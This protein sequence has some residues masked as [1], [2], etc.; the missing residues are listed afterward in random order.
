MNSSQAPVP[1]VDAS[2]TQ[3]HATFGFG[4]NTNGTKPT[5]PFKGNTP[6]G[7][8]SIGEVGS[9]ASSAGVAVGSS[10]GKGEAA[11]FSFGPFNMNSSQAP[12][13][14]VGASSTQSHATFGFGNNTNGTKPT[15]PFKGN[16]PTVGFSIGEVGS[17]ASS[18]GV[19]VGSS[20]GKGEAATA[21][22]SQAFVNNN[23]GAGPKS[24]SPFTQWR[25]Y[26]EEKQAPAGSM[27]TSQMFGTLEYAAPSKLEAC[28][29]SNVLKDITGACSCDMSKECAICFDPFSFSQCKQIVICGHIF[30]KACIDQSIKGSISCPICRKVSLH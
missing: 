14:D 12:A 7:G 18:A 15:A 6:T 21:N 29:D 23:S 28:V 20:G 17:F 11:S 19:A 10:G 4:N 8:F 26:H 27:T 9:F 22:S 30:H 13:P 1:D 25:R 24:N 16:T 3:S 5:A 2:S